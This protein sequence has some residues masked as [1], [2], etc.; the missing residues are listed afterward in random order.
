M[1]ALIL[2]GL[3]ALAGGLIWSVLG[4]IFGDST[5]WQDIAGRAELR[6]G[7]LRAQVI[8]WQQAAQGWQ[9]Q[10]E[11]YQQM[12]RDQSKVP[13]APSLATVPRDG[14]VLS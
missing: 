1:D 5:D 8:T 4:M 3:S 11:H 2:V 13:T 10:A 6:N 9:E 7:Q 14:N 12:L